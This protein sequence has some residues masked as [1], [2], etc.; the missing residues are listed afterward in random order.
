MAQAKNEQA[1]RSVNEQIQ[2]AKSALGE[3]KFPKSNGVA[4]RFLELAQESPMQVISKTLQS[5]NDWGKMIKEYGRL[6]E[7]F[8]AIQSRFTDA[9]ENVVEDK[10]EFEEATK[11]YYAALLVMT[12]CQVY[13][14]NALGKRLKKDDTEERINLLK[15]ESQ[16]LSKNIEAFKMNV[17]RAVQNMG[18]HQL[19]SIK[20]GEDVRLNEIIPNIKSAYDR[21]YDQH[22]PFWKWVKQLFQKSDRAKEINFLNALSEHKE[23]S[24]FVR[25]QAIRLVHGKIQTEWFGEGSKLGKMLG[26]LL[27]NGKFFVDKNSDET[28]VNFLEQHEELKEL[29]PDSLKDYLAEQD[30]EYK[31]VARNV[32]SNRIQ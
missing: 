31:D 13:M 5:K 22:N 11:Q 26:G 29:M 14:A 23:C 20:K 27:D 18:E 25:F 4:L 17:N 32:F 15:N 7:Q 24:E 28:L 2:S 1:L 3:M 16:T 6:Q 9:V 12:D 30:K 19:T 10:K 21:A 8:N